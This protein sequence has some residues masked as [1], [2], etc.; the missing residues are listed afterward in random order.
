M[1]KLIKI[2]NSNFTETEKSSNVKNYMNL[3]N[4]SVKNINETNNKPLNQDIF[5]KFVLIC[6]CLNRIVSSVD[7]TEYLLLDCTPRIPREYYIDSL[8]KLGTY[9]KTIFEIVVNEK[10]Q[11]LHK[12]DANRTKKIDLS[13]NEI[14]NSIFN[15][16]LQTF[17]S[18]LQVEFEHPETIIQITSLYTQ[19]S[20]LTQSDYNKCLKYIIESLLYDPCNPLI[21]YNLGHIYQRLNQLE[22][23]L[24][25]YKLSIKLNECNLTKGKNL[26]ESQKL[27]INSLNGIGSI[28]RNIKQWPQA[29]HFI[30]KAHKIKSDDPDINNQLGVIY[31]EMRNTQLAKKHY[32]LAITHYEKTFVSTDP[33][34]FLSDIY[35]NLGHMYSYDGDNNKSIESYNKS[36]SICP[37]NILAF[38]NKLMNLNYIFDQL[39]D[40]LYI[41]QQHCKINKIYNKNHSPYKFGNEY[42]KENNKINIGIISGDFANHP[43]SY[44]ISTLLKYFDHE[45]FN[46]T[47]YSECII[48]TSCYNKNL[49]FKIIKNMS[50][51]SASNLIYNDNIHILLDLTGHTAFNRL[52]IFAFKPAPIQITYIGY[53]FTTG[54][55][56]MDYRITDSICDGI[57]DGTSDDGTSDFSISQKFYTEKLI[58]LKNCFLCYSPV[59]ID[60]NE[61]DFKLIEL[62]DTPRLSNPQK[63][64]IAC[65]NRI[66]KIT[67]SVIIEFNKI[68]LSNS[69]ITFLFKTKAL[70]NSIV[71][72]E[73]VNKFDKNVQDRIKI[74]DCTLS[75]SQHIETYNQADIAID[76]FPYS[77]T[78][79][80]CEALTMGVP[81]F[82]WYDTTTYFHPQNVTASILK[83]S[84]LNFY[85]CNNTQEII[86]KIKSLEKEPLEFWKN[87]KLNTRNKFLNGKVC[88][89][90]EYIKNIQTLFTELYNKTKITGF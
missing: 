65:F 8:F 9:L 86:N 69:N 11:E 10:I 1:E 52:D 32:L 46:I 45:K 26:I 55:N 37:K 53:P 81:V 36:L 14:D 49:K 41:T 80:S 44:F 84:D 60:Q 12:N 2:I 23:S 77:G 3:Y 73:F 47:C 13:L 85:V 34:F 58:S 79:T 90:T 76:T 19:L 28:Y 70:I 43:V 33:K 38:Q 61:V 5:E 64:V 50:Q 21:H 56:E 42:F 25:H 16:T 68:L 67:D 31:T 6:D 48:N 75:H 87:L 18:I 82:T 57:C 51:E 22:Q 74:L 66:N 30:L 63:L 15:K 17:N 24:I 62:K 59:E 27:T 89:K 4:I 88:N 40:N 71:K 83:N 78:T 35:L 20:Y 7:T 72:S 39:D 54:L 29:L